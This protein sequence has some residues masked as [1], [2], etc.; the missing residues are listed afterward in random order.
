MIWDNAVEGYPSNTWR[1]ITGEN[2]DDYIQ[3]GTIVLERI[4]LSNVDS[5]SGGHVMPNANLSTQLV[6]DQPSLQEFIP[7]HL[8][9]L[10]QVTTFRA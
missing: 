2:D 3:R 8:G 7:S 1:S 6:Q 9:A 5:L 10:G 4:D